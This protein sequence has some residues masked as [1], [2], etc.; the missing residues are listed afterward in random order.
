MP[1]MHPGTRWF[2]K[3][4]ETK[5]SGAYSLAFAFGKKLLMHD[6]FKSKSEFAEHAVFYGEQTLVAAITDAFHNSQVV[7]DSK[8]SFDTQKKKV[9]AFIAR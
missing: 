1:L 4:F 9:L 2:D 8:F 7:K 6:I 5:I 3:Y